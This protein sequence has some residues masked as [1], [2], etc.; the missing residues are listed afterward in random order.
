VRTILVSSAL[1]LTVTSSVC[2]GVASA[3]AA[4]QGILHTFARQTRQVDEP[5][6][7]LIAQEAASQQ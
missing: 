2:L 3:Y 6:P 7:A 4:I 1:L 5:A